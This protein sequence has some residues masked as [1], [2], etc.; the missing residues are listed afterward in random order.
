M[1]LK[2][3]LLIRM[4]LLGLL[5][6]LGA[7][8]YV[9]ARSGQQA[10]RQIAASADQLKALLAAD[11]GRRMVSLDADARYPDLSWAGPRSGRRRRRSGGRSASSTRRSAC[12][13]CGRTRSG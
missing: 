6:W 10:A 9:V 2:L 12:W 8:V 4:L 7:S 1:N 5:C 13:R 11:V 3:H